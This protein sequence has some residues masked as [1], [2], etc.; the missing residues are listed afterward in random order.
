MP[1]VVTSQDLR[2][3]VKLA[4]D[5]LEGSGLVVVQVKFEVFRQ[6]GTQI[7]RHDQCEIDPRLSASF[8]FISSCS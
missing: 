1:I 7:I 4:L 2:L 5:T 8:G 6:N 3:L